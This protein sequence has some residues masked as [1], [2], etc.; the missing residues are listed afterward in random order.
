MA[1]ESCATACDDSTKLREVRQLSRSLFFGKPSQSKDSAE[2]E[3]TTTEK[4]LEGWRDLF[5]QISDI[6][7]NKSLYLDDRTLTLTEDEKGKIALFNIAPGA[8]VLSWEAKKKGGDNIKVIVEY[9]TGEN[10]EPYYDKVVSFI[11]PM[12]N[13]KSADPAIR[14]NE[15]ATHSPINL[16]LPEVINKITG[17]FAEIR[18]K[19]INIRAEINT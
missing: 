15:D 13:S 10:E 4:M 11:L 8:C 14:W 12:A 3:P 2:D 16:G 9:E 7:K 6:A 5:Q 1:K 18:E 17:T 19:I